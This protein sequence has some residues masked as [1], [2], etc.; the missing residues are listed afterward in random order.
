MNKYST[1]KSEPEKIHYKK[2][3][4]VKMRLYTN[5]AKI[6]YGSVMDFVNMSLFRQKMDLMKNGREHMLNQMILK[7][8]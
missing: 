7:T 5:H 4:L 3:D 8:M 2:M 6:V 1:K